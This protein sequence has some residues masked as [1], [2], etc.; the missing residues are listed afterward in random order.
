MKV[1]LKAQQDILA[2]KNG[3]ARRWYRRII[4]L[5]L[6]LW[7]L[8]PH[9]CQDLRDSK[10][11]VLTSGKHL[12]RYKNIVHQDAGPQTDVLRWM[13]ESAKDAKV[14]PEGLAGVLMHDE[15]KIQEDLVLKNRDGSLKLVGWINNGE[16]GNNIRVLRDGV[17]QQ[18]LAT[19]VSAVL[20]RRIHR[21]QI[22]CL[23]LSN[24]RC[25]GK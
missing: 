3:Q 20:F 21:I 18:V 23:P 11:V 17:P 12:R 6:S 8:S 14:G 15:T 9:T 16:E 24:D 13:F 4:S 10:I 7:K 25:K 22:P 5:C 19:E 1:L 2:A